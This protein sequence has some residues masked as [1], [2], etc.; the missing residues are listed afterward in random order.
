[1]ER[2]LMIGMLSMI[3]LAFLSGAAISATITI[4]GIVTDSYTIES[5]DGQIYDVADTDQ[6]NALLEHVGKQVRVTGEV[7]EENVMTVKSFKV[8]EE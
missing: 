1:M 5:P 3:L 7:D 6:G 4:E 8:I 2:K